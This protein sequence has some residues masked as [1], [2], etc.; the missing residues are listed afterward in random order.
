MKYKNNSKSFNS[1][2]NDPKIIQEKI[3]NFKQ[4]CQNTLN[5]GKTWNLRNF[6]EKKRK[7]CTKSLKYLELLIIFV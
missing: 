1:E 3:R 4:G 6:S 7:F 2:V 5:I